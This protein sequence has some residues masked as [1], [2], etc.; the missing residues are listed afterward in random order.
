MNLIILILT[1]DIVK[2]SAEV[3]KDERLLT[4]DSFVV[5]FMQEQGLTKLATTNGDFDRIGGIAV[6]KPTDLEGED[7]L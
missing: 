1:L 6:H 5:A 2:A 3:R 4:N 7:T